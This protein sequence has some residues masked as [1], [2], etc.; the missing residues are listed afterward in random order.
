MPTQLAKN[1]KSFS[2]YLQLIHMKENFIK[3]KSTIE[4]TEGVHDCYSPYYSDLK[5]PEQTIKTRL[6]L[7]II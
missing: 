3:E 4:K 2:L 1:R 7:L 5:K 6:K